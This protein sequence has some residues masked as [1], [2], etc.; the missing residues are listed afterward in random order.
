V[1]D[2]L[3]ATPKSLYAKVME[4]S[5]TIA[6]NASGNKAIGTLGSFDITVGD[7]EVSGELEAYFSTVAAVSAVKNNADCGFNLIATKDNAGFVYDI[8]LLSLGGGRV[9]VEKDEPIKLPLEQSGAENEMGYTLS[10][11]YF[12]YLPA[13]A[14][15]TTD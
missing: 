13:A 5:I 1:T 4:A 8:P 2:P 9:S 14:M 15:A 12:N 11:T 7:F 6:N 10:A 3:K